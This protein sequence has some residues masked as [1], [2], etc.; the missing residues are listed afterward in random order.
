MVFY[1][2]FDWVHM[3]VPHTWRAMAVFSSRLTDIPVEVIGYIAVSKPNIQTVH[4]KGNYSRPHHHTNWLHLIESRFLN[5]ISQLLDRP[6][7]YPIHVH[8]GGACS[9]RCKYLYGV[10]AFDDHGRWGEIFNN[11]SDMADEDLCMW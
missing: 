4:E 3:Y 5:R 1:S 10:W 11:S 7:D 6:R 9:A 2:I 8:S